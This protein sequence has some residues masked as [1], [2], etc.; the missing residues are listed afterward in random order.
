MSMVCT[1]AMYAFALPGQ[2]MNISPLLVG[3]CLRSMRFHGLGDLQVP[4]VF[5]TQFLIAAVSNSPT[6]VMA[7]L[8]MPNI[9]GNFLTSARVSALTSPIDS[10]V[11]G[12]YR[13]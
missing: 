9:G 10:S 2:S 6:T 13:G 8:L 11:V 12:A 4:Q 5:S 1:A 7:A 3:K